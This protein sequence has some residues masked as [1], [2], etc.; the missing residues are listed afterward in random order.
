MI[1]ILSIPLSVHG[2]KTIVTSLIKG[3]DHKVEPVVPFN[4]P[5]NWAALS[6]TGLIPVMQDGDFTL[7]DSSAIC[8]YLERKHPAPAILPVDGKLAARALWFDSY[9]GN[10]Y[11]DV[12][13]G[14]FFQTVIGPRILNQPTDPAAIDRIQTTAVPKF[15]SYL[16]GQASGPFLVGNTLTLAD[17]AIASNLINYQYLGFRIDAVRFPHLDKF[18]RGI[19][20]HPAFRQAL[21]NEQP[22]AEQ[23][24][25]DRGF[26][27]H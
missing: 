3:I 1:T 7:P 11:R 8:Q 6:P 22:F 25:L 10:L 15:F 18:A 17:I 26:I 21:A 5:P 2:R 12:T 20:A 19:I 9:A 16:D 27:S 13:H 23:M 4:P 14:L 24:G